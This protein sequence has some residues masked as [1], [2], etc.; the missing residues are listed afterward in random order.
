[1]YQEMQ[2]KKQDEKAKPSDARRWGAPQSD[3]AKER[4]R[5]SGDADVFG[6]AGHSMDD[7]RIR[8]R[9]AG[10]R[11]AP[12]VQRIIAEEGKA[13]GE[14]V[15]KILKIYA[16][17]YPGSTY[18]SLFWVMNASKTK[19]SVVNERGPSRYDPQEKKL[20][21]N[22]SIFD[23]LNGALKDGNASTISGLLSNICHELSHAY[24]F[25]GV[26][27][28]QPKESLSED[29]TMSDETFISTELRAWAREAIS[30][31]E[32]DKRYALA[33]DEANSYLINGWKQV[34]PDMLDNLSGNKSNCIIRRLIQYI[35]MRLR[36]PLQMEEIQAWMDD[37]ARKEKY[38]VQLGRLK[39][40][41]GKKVQE[42]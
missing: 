16:E 39:D 32:I 17:R 27:G 29:G 40:S 36:P 3:A 14:G 33:H 41:V 15:D 20:Y 1:M 42:H 4:N 18:S 37:P 8:Y 26:E 10:N 38:R 34:N 9:S 21:L 25:I 2:L 28:S 30:I 6:G 35:G 19:I 22:F 24:D 7:V 11:P 23:Q 31:L 12:V 13:Q 5:K